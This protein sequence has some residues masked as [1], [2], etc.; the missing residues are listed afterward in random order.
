MSSK[1]VMLWLPKLINWTLDLS[2]KR[3]ETWASLYAPVEPE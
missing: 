3:F 1:V 2:D